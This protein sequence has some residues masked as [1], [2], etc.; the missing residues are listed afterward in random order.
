MSREALVYGS[1]HE[2]DLPTVAR[3]LHLAFAG[4]LDGSETWVRAAGIEHMRV[5]RPAAHAPPVGCLLRIP[6]GQYF[7]G[8]SVPMLGIAGVAVAPE[9]RGRGVAAM[10]MAECMREMARD[11]FPIST[12]YPSTIG[13]YRK[14]GYELAGHRFYTT[15]NVGRIDAPAGGAAVRAL[16][17]ADLPAVRACYA[18]FA[19]A[20]DGLLDRGEY[21]WGRVRE[22]R[23]TRYHA[24]G[25][26][27]EAGGLDGYIML[28]QERDAK[29][30]YHAINISDCAF[31][32]A[33]AGRR[34]LRF[35][36]DFATMGE[37]AT[38]WGGPMHPLVTLMSSRQYRC[39]KKDH[40]MVRVLDVKSALESRGYPACVRAECVLNVRDPIV[41][42][43]AGRWRVTIEGGRAEVSR[44]HEARGA[45]ATPEFGCDI[46]AVAALFSGVLGVR[47]L[48][49]L[50]W[51]ETGDA[52]A[53]LAFDGAIPVATP[54]MTDM[55]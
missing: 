22:L 55:F 5:V 47:Q 2:R 54:W 50:G 18:R 17:D 20:F 16:G 32:T 40:W 24:F 27:D 39:E 1:M 38:V 6:M 33:D 35:L 12:L 15:I 44:V 29:M 41:T 14:V 53:A 28:A 51:L 49:A 7:G 43:N 48:L 10:L 8:R 4:P 23:G 31:V 42:A 11:G 45:G 3:L 34:L 19:A 25:V 26:A 21:C 46:R 52:A 9:A 30:G 13:L 36:A 37:T